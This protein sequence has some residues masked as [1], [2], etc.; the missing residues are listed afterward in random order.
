MWGLRV[1]SWGLRCGTQSSLCPSLLTC[2][3]WLVELLWTVLCAPVL[4]LSVSILLQIS[5]ICCWPHACC[6]TTCPDLAVIDSQTLLACL[7]TC[8]LIITV[9]ED[10]ARLEHRTAALDA[11]EACARCSRPLAAPAPASAGPAGGAL[12]RLYLFPTGNA[13][14][15]SCLCA[16]VCEL[17]PAVQRGRIC[18]LAERLA[19]LPEGTV[20]A[21]AT[22]DAPASSVEA[23]RQLLEEEVAV[24]DP[25]EGE[26][27]VRHITKP[28]VAPEEQQ[29]DS[30]AL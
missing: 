11:A 8:L 20:A 29:A 10:L 14:H 19:G 15:A 30:W 4:V 16:E 25:F 18:Q 12:P 5:F 2:G 24:E 28:F 27:V 17:A 23:L 6:L 7:T 9:R 22:P 13:F 26:L 21:P 1:D 3:N